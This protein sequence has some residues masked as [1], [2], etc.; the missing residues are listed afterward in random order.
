M[1]N[2][3]HEVK[4]SIDTGLRPSHDA[5]VKDAAKQVK[6]IAANISKIK[7]NE[8]SKSHQDITDIGQRTD[9]HHHAI[10]QH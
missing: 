4:G 8:S 7:S 6:K 9:S 5:A 10:V 1:H 2:V 3:V